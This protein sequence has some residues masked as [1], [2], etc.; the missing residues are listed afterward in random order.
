[1][2]VLTTSIYDFDICMY[3]LSAQDIKCSLHAFLPAWPGILALACLG[4][5]EP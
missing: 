4:L 1:M 5:T 2:L 3:R